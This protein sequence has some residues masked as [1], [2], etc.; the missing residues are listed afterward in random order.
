MNHSLTDATVGTTDTD[1]L[2]ASAKTTHGMAFEVSQHYTFMDYIQEGLP[3]QIIIG[4]M[5][6]FVLPLLF[7]F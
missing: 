2:V 6:V 5:M 1:I 4:I 7:P 3:L